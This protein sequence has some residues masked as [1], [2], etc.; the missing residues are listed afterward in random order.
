MMR[1]TSPIRAAAIAL[2]LTAVFL[3]PIFSH[4]S[5]WGI[6]DWDQHAFYH[7]AGR[8]SLLQYG[9]LPQWNPYYCGGTDLLANPQSRVLSPTFP[10]VLLF[11]TVVGLKIELLLFTFLGLLGVYALGRHLG[12]DRFCAWLAPVVYFL[13]PAYALPV[14]TGMSWILS[15]AFIPWVVLA[16]LKG[17]RGLR[18]RLG[19]GA[20]LALMYLGG[21]VYPVVITLT[22]LGFLGLLSVAEHGVKKTALVLGTMVVVM[23]G[24]GAAKFF[25]SI[26]FMQEYPRR[27]D[28]ESGFSVEALRI[29]LFHRDQRLETS[30]TQFDGSHFNDP[31]RLFQGI[32]SDFDDIGMYIG[33]VVAVLFLAGLL[34]RGRSH[35][36][37]GLALP[38]FLWLSLGGRASPSL[39]NALHRLPVYESF[40]YAE[41]FRLVWFLVLCLFAGL[42]LQGM[43]GLLERRSPGRRPGAVV[44]LIVAIVALDLFFVTRPIY[45]SAYSIPPIETIPFSSFQQV[46]RLETYDAHGFTGGTEWKEYGSWG[47]QY[48]ALLMNLGTVECYEPAYVPIHAAAM[49][50]PGYRGEVYLDGGAGTVTTAY[51]SP[52]RLRYALDVREPAVLVVNQNYYSSWRAHDGRPVTPHNGLLSV[53]VGP[54]DRFV[55]LR[56][57]R[58]SFTV[59]L[60]VSAMSWI[61][62]IAILIYSAAVTR[63]PGTTSSRLFSSKRTQHLVPPS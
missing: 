60:A 24:L 55:E 62:L 45:R 52:N 1:A 56:Y 3:S 7:E 50:S 14:S 48:P 32:S 49:G 37:L 31:D 12:L 5:N 42:G 35:W 28:D 36:K 39:F 9:Q 8:V 63:E 15:T 58:A 34:T 22:F 27:A 19:G 29:G 33:P 59:G 41:R 26:A 11:G 21:G 57:R 51:W 30:R 44:A 2:V 46:G 25:P 38:V 43:R 18:A 47:A 17:F 6:Q 53:E 16:Y 61:G 10:I 54:G 23:L 40:R 13:G 4:V 20:G